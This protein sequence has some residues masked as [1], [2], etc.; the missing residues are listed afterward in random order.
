M[1]AAARD[2]QIHKAAGILAAAYFLHARAAWARSK[3]IAD[4]LDAA[5]DDLK[6]LAVQTR[7]AHQGCTKPE[8]QP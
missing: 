8:E 6:G 7:Y 5:A 1:T 3:A 4:A 2:A